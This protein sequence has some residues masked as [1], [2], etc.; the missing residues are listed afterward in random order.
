MPQQVIYL[1]LELLERLCY[2]LAKEVFDSEQEPIPPFSTHTNTLLES[3]LHNPQQ[4]FGNKDLYPTLIDKAAILYYS[5]I[6]NHPF[7]N[8]NKRI[9]TATLLVFLSLNGYWLDADIDELTE[10][11]IR[12]ANSDPALHKETLADIHRW[13][14]E[15]LKQEETSTL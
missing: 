1:D 15:H 11:A 9:A 10:R 6:K 14:K 7:D 13:M 8:G 3:A 4:T 5:L 12:V 2:R